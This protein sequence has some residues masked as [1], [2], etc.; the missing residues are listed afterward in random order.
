MNLDGTMSAELDAAARETFESAARRIVPTQRAK[1]RGER[2]SRLERFVFPMIGDMPVGSIRGLHIRGVLVA[3]LPK[4]GKTSLGHVLDDIAGVLD[5]LW[6]DE[7]LAENPARRVQVP[8]AARL[9]ERPRAVLTD[10]EFTRLVTWPALHPELKCLFMSSRFLG[11]ARTSDLH[12]WDW[13]HV[14]VVM[15]R[16]AHLPRP[17]TSTR[18]RLALPDQLAQ[19][20]RGWWHLEGEPRKGP[21]FPIREGERAGARRGKMSHARELRKALWQAGVRRG[22]TRAECELQT[23]TEQTRRAD[24]HSF[25]RAYNTGLAKAGVNVQTAMKLAGH[26]SPVTHMKYV[27]PSE[28]LAVPNAALP[29]GLSVAPDRLSGIS[30]RAMLDRA[31]LADATLAGALRALAS[32]LARR[33]HRARG[34]PRSP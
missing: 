24:F 32:G 33:P 29:K 12:A 15:W 22:E 2:L 19:V 20:L 3:A 28:P 4:L 5:E 8:G 25:R 6:R 18:D 21:V 7:I 31:A 14:D 23:D 34:K 11:G 16:S 10:D 13:S 27:L 26:R 9:D 1:T 30:A 17:K